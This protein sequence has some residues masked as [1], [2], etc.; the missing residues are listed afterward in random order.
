MKKLQLTLAIAALAPMLAACAPSPDKV[1]AHIGDL[2]AKEMPEGAPEISEEDKKKGMDECVKKLTKQQEMKGMVKYK[3]EASCAM[4]ATK[5]E[6]LAKC[7]E[8]K[9]DAK[10]GEKKE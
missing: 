6:E 9:D 8:K 7:G 1:C 2:A 3:E 10:D 4:K 5:M